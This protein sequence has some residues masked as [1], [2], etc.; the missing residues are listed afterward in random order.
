MNS[1]LAGFV[2]LLCFAVAAKRV[3]L[4]TI[5]FL[6]FLA[7]T[8]QFLVGVYYGEPLTTARIV[9]FVCIWAAVLVFSFDALRFG[10]RKPQP[11]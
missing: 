11:I 7:P 4:T 6:Q 2:P 9:C 10:R 3:S 1:L 8:L 5:G